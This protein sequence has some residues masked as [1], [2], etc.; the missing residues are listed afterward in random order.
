[1]TLSDEAVAAVGN[2]DEEA[3]QQMRKK[4]NPKAVLG[5]VSINA[6]HIHRS[7]FAEVQDVCPE[8]D[9]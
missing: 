1:M 7:V 8:A 2:S 6:F 3:I 9:L 4:K 5:V